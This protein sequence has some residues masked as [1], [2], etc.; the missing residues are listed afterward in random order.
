MFMHTHN[1]ELLQ[2]RGNS[3]YHI[4][5]IFFSLFKWKKINGKWKRI[6][7]PL[8]EGMVDF[9]RYF[10]F[11]FVRNPWSRAV[12]F[13]KF[14]GHQHLMS[15]EKFV[16]TKLPQLIKEERWFY[17]PQY[18]FFY[19]NGQNKVDFIA[20]S[21]VRGPDDLEKL[22]SILYLQIHLQDILIL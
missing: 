20:L 3:P 7:T 9:D 12:S 11:G 2:Y 10:K 13:Y 19:V 15:F 21:F 6:F 14:H 18:D 16:V 5:T 4:A 22:Q 8:G 17:G 1:T